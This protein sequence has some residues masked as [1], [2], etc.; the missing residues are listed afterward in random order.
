MGFRT[1]LTIANNRKNKSVLNQHTNKENVGFPVTF[2]LPLQKTF[3]DDFLNLSTV[4]CHIEP[5][6]LL[7][8]D[9]TEKEIRLYRTGTHSDLFG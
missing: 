3:H 8:Y 7:I 9:I 1:R 5:D 4:Q 2:P 6:W